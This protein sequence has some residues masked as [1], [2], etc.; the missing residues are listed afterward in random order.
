MKKQ[1]MVC[2]VY[3]PCHVDSRAA[4]N[5]PERLLRMCTFILLALS[6]HRAEVLA[7]PKGLE[8][9][10]FLGSRFP[11]EQTPPRCKHMGPEEQNISGVRLPLDGYVLSYM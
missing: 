5:V 10:C 6:P 7:A 8:I 3:M 9:L 4:L 11:D 2:L 1:G